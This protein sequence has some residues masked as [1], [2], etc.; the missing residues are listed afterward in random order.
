[1]DL[2]SFKF[3]A[4]GLI[5][6]DTVYGIWSTWEDPL[7]W[8]TLLSDGADVRYQS[9][10]FFEVSEDKSPGL[11]EAGLGKGAGELCLHCDP[12][13]MTSPVDQF[14]CGLWMLRSLTQV[15]TDLFS[16]RVTKAKNYW[17]GVVRYCT[18]ETIWYWGGRV[19]TSNFFAYS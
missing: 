1:M 3:T 2:G 16:V 15:E 14:M 19:D 12:H 8:A 6:L 4:K 9:T 18:R 17:R 5:I 13:I 7:H 10:A 11:T